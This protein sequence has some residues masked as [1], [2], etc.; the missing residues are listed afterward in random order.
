MTPQQAQLNDFLVG[1]FNDILRLEDTSLRESCNNLSVSELHVLEAVEK[2]GPD[3]DAG[4]AELAAAL[5]VTAGTLSIAM[6]TLEQKGYA[7]RR[8]CETDK[9]RVTVALTPL[10]HPVLAAHRTF[11][12]ALV[13]KATA[14]LTDF[15]LNTLCA[16]LSC[17]H[18]HFKTM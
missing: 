4:M 1:V 14:Q 5:G 8:R 16:A 3:G 15:E 11:H 7:I 13:T 17:L 2:H 18:D 10:A 12:E 6:K 9:R